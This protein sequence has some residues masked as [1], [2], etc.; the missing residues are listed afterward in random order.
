MCI[1]ICVK[2][3]HFIKDMCIHKMNQHRTVISI[4]LPENIL[5]EGLHGL[6]IC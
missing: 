5:F 6:V 2:Y 3:I 1:L 4:E